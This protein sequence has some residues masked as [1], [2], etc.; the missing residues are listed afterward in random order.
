MSNALSSEV[1]YKMRDLEAFLKPKVSQEMSQHMES[2]MD[3]VQLNFVSRD[4]GQG[5]EILTQRYVAK[6]YFGKLLFKDFDPAV[7]YCNVAAWLMD[8][9]QMRNEVAGLNDPIV[10]L[11]RYNEHEAEITLNIEFE[12][13]IKVTEDSNGE[14][15]WK[16]KRWAI[17]PYDV[18]VAKQFSA[19]I[20]RTKRVSN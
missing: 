17:T 19:E 9:D 8:N 14:V 18:Y 15:Y 10:E 11:H 7:L 16:N 20:K 2:Y 5:M 6:L 1:G 12:E 3:S 4:M 13:P